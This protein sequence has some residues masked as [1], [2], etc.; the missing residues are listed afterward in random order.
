MQA[1]FCYFNSSNSYTN[2]FLFLGN[3]EVLGQ[4]LKSRS[5]IMNSNHK[6]NSFLTLNLNYQL[7]RQQ[8]NPL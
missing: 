8:N 1:L 6:K 7:E 3:D 2:L 4:M 5:L